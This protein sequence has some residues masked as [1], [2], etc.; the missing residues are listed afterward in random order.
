MLP[1]NPIKCNNHQCHHWWLH[2][3]LLPLTV[4]HPLTENLMLLFMASLSVRETQLSVHKL[5]QISL[6]SLQLINKRMLQLSRTQL[7]ISSYGKIQL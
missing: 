1:S 6:L 3:G 4:L 7:K 2:L 5:V